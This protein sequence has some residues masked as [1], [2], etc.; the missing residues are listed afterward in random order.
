MSKIVLKN[1]YKGF[2][3]VKAVDRLNLEIKEKEFITLLG[4]SG[5]GKTTTLRCLSGLEEPD[6]GEIYID[7]RCIFSNEKHINVPPG[8]RELGLVFQNYAL[9]PHMKVGKNIAFGLH[10][11]TD[12]SI[13]LQN[14]VDN[15]LRTVG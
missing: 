14:K 4:P 1:L 15:I 11:M 12:A 5:C 8:Q 7:D 3:S 2:G 10:K 6:G 9:W 13:N